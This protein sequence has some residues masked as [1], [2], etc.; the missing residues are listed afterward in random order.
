MTP[1][2]PEPTPLDP[3]RTLAAVA[4][5]PVRHRDAELRGNNH[6]VLAPPNA[7]FGSI[8]ELNF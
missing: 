7:S 4:L 5:D 1:D 2:A 8:H 3:S 6:A